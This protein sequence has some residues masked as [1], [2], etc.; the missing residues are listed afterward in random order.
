MVLSVL[1][2]CVS[3][4]V[5]HV[6]VNGVLH[7]S[8]PVVVLVC[9]EELQKKHFIV[10]SQVK[11]VMVDAHVDGYIP[12][13]LTH[14]I[15]FRRPGQTTLVVGCGTGILQLSALWLSA[16]FLVVWREV[17]IHLF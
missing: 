9:A 3:V 11:S 7:Q 6:V 14:P 12:V 5:V 13:Q 1:S 16:R 17:I 10:K 15:I 8:R 2:L 4:Q